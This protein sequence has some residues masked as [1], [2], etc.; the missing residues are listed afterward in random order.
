MR[1]YFL[2]LIK[3]DGSPLEYVKMGFW[4]MTPPG[5]GMKHVV[6]LSVPEEL[7]YR[8]MCL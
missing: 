8:Y 1:S 5:G 2:R 6:V 4:M 3:E 7:A